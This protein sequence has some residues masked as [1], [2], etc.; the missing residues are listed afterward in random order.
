MKNQQRQTNYLQEYSFSKPAIN[1]PHLKSG[2]LSMFF[3]K[4]GFTSQF[5]FSSLLLKVEM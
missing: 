5:D 3:H 2:R 4:A 1:I